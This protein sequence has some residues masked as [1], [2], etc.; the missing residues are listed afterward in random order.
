MVD[1][2]FRPALPPLHVAWNWSLEL[3]QSDIADYKGW[4]ENIEKLSAQLKYLQNA[5]I[6]TKDFIKVTKGNIKTYTY[7]SYF[8]WT[9]TGLWILLVIALLGCGLGYYNHRELAK[10][11]LAKSIGK[12]LPQVSTQHYSNLEPLDRRD[13][14]F[15]PACRRLHVPDHHHLPDHHQFR[16]LDTPATAPRSNEYLDPKELDVPRDVRQQPLDDSPLLG[17]C[18][19]DT[20]TA[21]QASHDKPIV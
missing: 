3:S 7:S 20:D 11:G 10:I 8:T 6:A 4:H 21:P 15:S 19:C 14:V 1:P 16:A 17:P 5:S 2:F 9:S 12:R 18:V 13:H